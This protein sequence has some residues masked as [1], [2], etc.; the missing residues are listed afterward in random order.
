[1]CVFLGCP[2][3]ISKQAVAEGMQQIA[4]FNRL[5]AWLN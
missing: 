3:C 2:P 1:L 5:L 4:G